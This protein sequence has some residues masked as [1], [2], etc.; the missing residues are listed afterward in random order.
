MAGVVLVGFRILLLAT[1]KLQQRQLPILVHPVA[2][3]AEVE[4]SG[5]NGHNVKLATSGARFRLLLTST[6]FQ[7]H[8]TAP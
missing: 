8:G 2:V 3:V 7:I 5:S 1:L 6:N 4:P